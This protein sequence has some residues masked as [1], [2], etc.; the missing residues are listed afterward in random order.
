LLAAADRVL[1]PLIERITLAHVEARTL[2]GIRDEL[3]PRLISGDLAVAGGERSA[4]LASEPWA[5]ARV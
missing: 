2:A 1:A 4:A 5:L 3:L